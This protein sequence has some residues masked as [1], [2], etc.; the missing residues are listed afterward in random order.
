[1][2][3]RLSHAE[4]NLADTLLAYLINM[5]IILMNATYNQTATRI[6]DRCTSITETRTDRHADSQT[7]RQISP[8]ALRTGG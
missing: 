1:M 3:A 4:R 8:V 6:D 7:E 5:K 2:R